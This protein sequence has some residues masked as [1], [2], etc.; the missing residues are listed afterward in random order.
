MPT[1]RRRLLD[2]LSRISSSPQLT[3]PSAL[4]SPLSPALTPHHASSTLTLATPPPHPAQTVQIPYG[5]DGE[6]L[7]ITIPLPP[8]PRRDLWTPLPPELKLHILSHLSTPDLLRTAP[9]SRDFASLT[10]DG[11]LWSTLDTT[12]YYTR[13]PASQLAALITSSAPFL[14]H[15]N[16]RGCLQLAAD[17]RQDATYSA[18]RNLRSVILEGAQPSKAALGAIVHRNAALVRLDVSGCRALTFS[19]A[20][21]IA[22]SLPALEAADVSWCAG[23]E[24]RGLKRI[25][26]GCGRL[27]ELRACG[28]NGVED[29]TVMSAIHSANRI[30]RLDMNSCAGLT[31]DAIRT[32]C[33]GPYHHSS[34]GAAP[35]PPRRLTW[36]AVSSCP[37][38]TDAALHVLAA[39]A[40]HLEGF[41]AAADVGVT[42]AGL[43]ALFGGARGLSHVD[44]EGCVA[45]SDAAVTALARHG[46]V[47]YLN[48]GSCADVGD[49][50]VV[51]VL[52]RCAG[53]R[54]V[55]ADGTAVTDRVLDEAVRAV[56]YRG[57]AEV[58]LAV[59]DCPGVT[60]E[61]VRAVMGQNSGGV[62]GRVKVKCYFGWQAVVDTHW[63]R[64]GRGE[65]GDAEKVERAWA[66]FMGGEEGGRRRRRRGGAWMWEGGAGAGVDRRGRGRCVVC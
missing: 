30:T 11:Q 48:V 57:V 6:S 18:P 64:C 16:L 20:R 62:G 9:T 34:S 52:R 26:E 33:L 51:E 58:A 31:D 37:R 2:R 54:C 19:V 35:P 5:T 4:G 47:V 39:H 44:V 59:Y 56:R 29:A 32:L 46:K 43:A 49:G 41:E 17:W 28:V 13:I 42:D 1:R 12:H 61:G 27:R 23:L 21:L 65:M 63:E 66:A 8:R 24:A 25:V 40:P 50:G 10:R 14:R 60:W 45:V 36:L 53:V 15:L 22:T 7:H 3:T 38:I 55:E